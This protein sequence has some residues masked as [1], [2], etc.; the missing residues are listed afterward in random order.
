MIDGVPKT[1]KVTDDEIRESIKDPINIIVHA[2]KQAL[3]KTPPELITDVANNGILLAGGGAL[4]KGLDS[5]IAKE[6]ELS[7]FVDDDPLTTVLRGTGTAL[8]QEK[9]MKHVFIN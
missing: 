7:V 4:L 2:V 8:V 3:E 6:S 5:L 1:V 9:T